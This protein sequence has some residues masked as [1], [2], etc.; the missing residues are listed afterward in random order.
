MAQRALV[1]NRTSFFGK[2][3]ELLSQSDKSRYALG[4]L[5]HKLYFRA[6]QRSHWAAEIKRQVRMIVAW[7]R[8]K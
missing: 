1:L 4:K 5:N 6:D 8:W 2:V 7:T 3:S